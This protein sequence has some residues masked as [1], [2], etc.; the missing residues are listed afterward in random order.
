[1][2]LKRWDALQQCLQDRYVLVA[3]HMSVWQGGKACMSANAALYMR[4]PAVMQGRIDVGGGG[5][6]CGAEQRKLG[7]QW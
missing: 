7:R 6:G 5:G 3:E 1:M 4:M 2:P